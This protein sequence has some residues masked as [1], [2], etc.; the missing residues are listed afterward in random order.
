MATL[1]EIAYNIRN[2]YR[3]G[4][5][6]NNDYLS[7]DQIKFLIKNYRAQYL[8]REFNKNESILDTFEQKVC[9]ELEK[10]DASQ[11]PDILM[12]YEVLRSK[13][14]LRNFLRGTTSLL[15]SYIGATN[16]TTRW[17][18]VPAFA[19]EWNK[20]NKINSNRIKAF[21]L[22]NY[23]YVFPDCRVKFAMV[24]GI[25]E[26]PKDAGSFFN[27]NGTACYNDDT[28]YPLPEDMI[29]GITKDILSIDIQMMEKLGTNDT[30]ND[31]LQN[32]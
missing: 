30:S 32:Q 27:E 29:S 13:E 16:G 11:C 28:D 31:T 22:D 20:Y 3:K 8:R 7:L 9:V 24:R 14:K 18:Y 1:N 12:G 2:L 23:L 26:D 5:G 19:M 15:I 10:V 6:S 17:Q 25:L 21:I 4:R